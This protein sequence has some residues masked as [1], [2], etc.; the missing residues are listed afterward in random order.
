[1]AAAK[2]PAKAAAKPP[3]EPVAAAAE[4]AKEAPPKEA[5]PAKE[6]PVKEPARAA[7]PAPAP[8]QAVGAPSDELP[9]PDL[10]EDV[11]TEAAL[12]R[13]SRAA[14]EETILG[15]HAPVPKKADPIEATLHGAEL[16]PAQADALE[17]APKGSIKGLWSAPGEEA[18]GASAAA[19]AEAGGWS[20]PGGGPTSP[21]PVMGRRRR[22]GDDTADVELDEVED[23][24]PRRR[25]PKKKRR[26]LADL[27][28]KSR[29]RSSRGQVEEACHR[30]GEA[31]PQGA[32]FCKSC[33]APLVPWRCSSCGEVNTV[34]AAFCVGCREPIQMLAS[35]LDVKEIE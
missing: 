34:D 21:L 5:A 19:P 31:N 32:R 20:E 15:G 16:D 23:V 14:I 9:V 6:P 10:D 25:A 4:P 35:P 18:T 8:A 30:C 26:R 11:S 29:R 28:A 22:R 17:K 12:R 1:K 3:V 13:S 7:E 33:S 27:G 24:A 2:E